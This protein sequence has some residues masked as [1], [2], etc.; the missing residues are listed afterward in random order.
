MIQ[1]QFLPN[2]LSLSDMFSTRTNT[3]ENKP[4]G[5]K[6]KVEGRDEDL[7]DMAV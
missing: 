2:Q 7:S 4:Q 1:L 3:I 6:R 5:N